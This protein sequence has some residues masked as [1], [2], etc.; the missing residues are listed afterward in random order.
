MLAASGDYSVVSRG[1]GVSFARSTI[2]SSWPLDQLCSLY[3]I[4]SV[5]NHTPRS[6]QENGQVFELMDR[7][8]ELQDKEYSIVTTTARNPDRS[9]QS[10]RFCSGCFSMPRVSPF[11][12][13]L[14]TFNSPNFLA[15]FDKRYKSIKKRRGVEKEATSYI[16]SGIPHLKAPFQALSP[17]PS[18]N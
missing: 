11:P 16:Q 17:V 18:H 6:D 3:N 8:S 9:S 2:W 4:R 15:A 14:P 7:L 12:M 13:D 1:I 5:A 10:Q